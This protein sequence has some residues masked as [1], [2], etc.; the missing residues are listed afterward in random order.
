MV[1]ES[2]KADAI[3]DAA[4]ESH[5]GDAECSER[6]I[7]VSHIVRTR[8]AR[9]RTI[10][11]SIIIPSKGIYLFKFEKQNWVM[12]SL[13]L[14]STN[15]QSFNREFKRYGLEVLWMMIK[16]TKETLISEKKKKQVIVQ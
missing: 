12:D 2:C 4:E 3:Q 6:L 8:I 15:T 1:E 14:V 16:R 9:G 11:Y 5:R 13:Q 7:P 10:W